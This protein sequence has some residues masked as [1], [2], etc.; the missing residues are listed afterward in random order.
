MNRIVLAALFALTAGLVLAQDAD[1][2]RVRRILSTTPLIDGHDDLPWA[3][4]QSASAPLEVVAYDLRERTPGRRGE[5]TSRV[6]RR[7]RPPSTATIEA[8]D[9]GAGGSP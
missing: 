5:A 3:I 6:L 7:E 2:E 4:R 9:G 8:L 1:L